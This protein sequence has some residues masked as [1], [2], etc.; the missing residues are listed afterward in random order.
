MITKE[1][2]RTEINFIQQVMLNEKSD[3]IEY[4]YWMGKRDAYAA[5]IEKAIDEDSWKTVEDFLNL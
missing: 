5:L 2:L 3:E 4:T 1:A